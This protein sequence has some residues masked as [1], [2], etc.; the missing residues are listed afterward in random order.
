MIQG[1]IAAVPSAPV[2]SSA[3][4][5]PVAHDKDFS[6]VLKSSVRTSIGTDSSEKSPSATDPG[7]NDTSDSTNPIQPNVSAET[8][9]KTAV[10]DSSAAN[11]PKDEQRVQD[12]NEI[13]RQSIFQMS[14]GT[15]QIICQPLPKKDASATA[16][17]VTQGAQ[18]LQAVLITGTADVARD[19]SRSS[20]AAQIGAETPA[21]SQTKN[22]FAALA[23][24]QAAST[25]KIDVKSQDKTSSNTTDALFSSEKASQQSSSPDASTKDR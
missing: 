2:V 10:K 1:L 22:F 13:L 20:A 6:S 3:N 23:T 4:A 12:P 24:N 8:Q 7:T 9:G 11:E 18:T 17:S 21:A 25:N 19:L 15:Q 14:P 5:S 16:E